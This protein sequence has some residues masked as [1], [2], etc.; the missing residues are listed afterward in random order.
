MLDDLRWHAAA[1]AFPM[2]TG[3]ALQAFI[4]DI[5][6]NGLRRPIE[7]Y[8]GERWPECKGLGLDGRNR[9]AACRTLGIAPSVEYLDD[10]RVGASLTAYIASINVARR[11]LTSSQ[12]A[13]VAVELK[14]QFEVENRA[15]CLANLKQNQP[16]GATE[17]QKF[18]TRQDLENPGKTEVSR[19]A[20]QAADIVGTNRQYV[21][22]AEVI[23]QESAAL[24]A[25]VRDGRLTIHNARTAL[26]QRADNQQAFADLDSGAIGFDQFRQLCMLK[27]GFPE[28]WFRL[29]RGIIDLPRA[30][31]EAR[32]LKRRAKKAAEAGR[33][34]ADF[35]AAGARRVEAALAELGDS[36]TVN[37]I[38]E[39]ANV[40]AKFAGQVIDAMPDPDEP[41]T[42]RGEEVGV[43]PDGRPLHLARD[44][45]PTDRLNR[46]LGGAMLHV[47]N[48]LEEL[49][50]IVDAIGQLQ[51]RLAKAAGRK[52]G[53]WL[54]PRS[55]ASCLND[56]CRLVRFGKPYCVCPSCGGMP[57]MPKGCPTCRSTG[58]ICEGNFA[59]LNNELKV[60][61]SGYVN[62]RACEPPLAV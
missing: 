9:L 55:A 30:V 16:A 46:P 27:A 15:I 18:D 37:Q 6:V 50:G 43:G 17:C 58:F 35:E 41:A 22:D 38:A 14:N 39:R 48:D 59:G 8:N 42:P 31:A 56:A 20:Q 24:A 60:V 4:E 5:R 33:G 29:R 47:F 32:R 45:E 12:A 7:V 3:D 62:G 40:S 26:K 1:E 13:M 54:D 52:S 34:D 53:Q 10:T 25:L 2:M 61:A 11:H 28:V 21:Y 23:I 51:A 36:A 49:D 44:G 19:S 57:A